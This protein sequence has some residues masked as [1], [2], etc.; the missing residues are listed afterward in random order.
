LTHHLSAQHDEL[1]SGPS[2]RYFIGVVYDLHE[3]SASQ[4]QR[5]HMIDHD[6]VSRSQHR[7]SHAFDSEAIANLDTTCS[8]HP[9]DERTVLGTCGYLRYRYIYVDGSIL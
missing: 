5:A 3:L 2:L 8:T 9:V 7:R 1:I 4:G 6:W